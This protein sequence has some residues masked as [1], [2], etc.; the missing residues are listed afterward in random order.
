VP[1]LQLLKEFTCDPRPES[2]SVSPDGKKVVIMFGS[3]AMVYDVAS[4]KELARRILGDSPATYARASDKL[5]FWPLGEGV[6]QV[7]HDDLKRVVWKS[8]LNVLES[9]LVILAR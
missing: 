8:R 2:I 6:L 9:N 7:I 5:A 4:G 3:E 1:K